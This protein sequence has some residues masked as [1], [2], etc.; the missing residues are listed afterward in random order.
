[1]A[2]RVETLHRGTVDLLHKVA[3]SQAML[4]QRQRGRASAGAAQ[5]VQTRHLDIAWAAAQRTVAAT[6]QTVRNAFERD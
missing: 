1:L 4:D 2:A 3:S 6:L 5:T